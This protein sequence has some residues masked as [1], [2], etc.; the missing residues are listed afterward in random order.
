M[1]HAD[2][3]P[4]YALR[5]LHSEEVSFV[6]FV[7]LTQRTARPWWIDFNARPQNYDDIAPGG[8]LHMC[9]Y[10]THP[11]VFRD[12]NTGDK[13]LINNDEIYFPTSALYDGNKPIYLPIYITF[14]VYSLKDCCL[15]C[16][17][18]HVK[19]EDYIKLEIPQSLQTDLKNSPHLLREIKNLSTRYRNS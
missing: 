19:L 11:W 13:L 9:T 1:A 5:S 2:E 7:N 15:Q 10:R 4:A 8:T 18:K 16:I 14:P 3:Q 6:R 12:A 17:R